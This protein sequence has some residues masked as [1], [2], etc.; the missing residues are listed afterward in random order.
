MI[1]GLFINGYKS[2]SST[3]Y[4][5]LS[6]NSNSQFTA[7]LGQNGV[8]KSAIL[9]SI[10][11]FFN[12]K[13]DWNKNKTSS[14]EDTFVSI[15]FKIEIEKFNSYI[16]SNE[17][18]QDKDAFKEQ[19]YAMNNLLS[20]GLVKD[21]YSGP[22]YTNAIKKFEEELHSTLNKENYI[23]ILL[24]RKGKGDYAIKPFSGAMQKHIKSN[25]NKDIFISNLEK[26]IKA[27]YTFIYIPVEQRSKEVLSLE[28]I[29]MQR[30]MNKDIS[31]NIQY[32]LN[33]KVQQEDGKK[34]KVINLLN[35]KLKSFMNS[36]NENLHD[37]D[38]EYSKDRKKE[39]IVTSDLVGL[40]IKEYFSTKSLKKKNNTRMEQ[41][42]SGEQR[43]AIIEVIVSFLKNRTLSRE[44][45]I[46]E[47]IIAIDEPEISQDLSNVYKQFDSLESLGSQYGYQ[48]IITTHWYGLLPII[49]DGTFLI[50]N[51]QKNDEGQQV[52]TFNFHNYLDRKEDFPDDIHLKS[53]FD[54]TTSLLGYLRTHPEN[55]LI[56]CEGG[57]DKRYLEA[58]IDHTNIK[59]LPVGG[60]G[61]VK[62]MYKMMS[63]PITEKTVKLHENNK[64]LF[65]VDTDNLAD[66]KSGDFK[67]TNHLYIG[68]MQSLNK[69]NRRNDWFE[70]IDLSQ[71][72]VKYFNE[73]RI[74]DILQADAFYDALLDLVQKD[75]NE[76]FKKIFFDF[77]RTTWKLSN[78]KSH[79]YDNQNLP[80]KMLKSKGKYFDLE[81]QISSFIELNKTQLSIAYA[82]SYL[83]VI[84]KDFEINP[85]V[86]EIQR[87]LNLK[88]IS[89]IPAHENIVI[90]KIEDR[91]EVLT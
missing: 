47:I 14:L 68:R 33:E 6:K 82:S 11:Y 3:Q 64:V 29:D 8:G 10:D 34:L 62:M 83:K 19:V 27:H 46:D 37:S 67:S 70:I 69:L 88:D 57:T 15:A 1:Y 2:Y 58:M 42:S 4:I 28:N 91:I 61:N 87:I 49:N 21:Y 54:L 13:V 74:E 35:S 20:K 53:F 65:L 5:Q 78:L 32:I 44:K 38:F 52:N 80:Q 77:E 43:R 25:F 79:S 36:I 76:D 7:V 48:V 63:L 59:I 90:E 41:L 75:D 89:R 18:I 51:K 73:T 55:R 23:F 85:L 40:I 22:I 45:N 60:K 9:E 72:N 24:G 30:I 26:L 86:K 50:V 84:Q 31:D 39:N 16:E 12:G 71:D 17:L 66:I 81:H 56:L